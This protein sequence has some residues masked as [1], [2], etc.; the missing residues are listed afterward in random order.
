MAEPG[1][2]ALP[3]A[4]TGPVLESRD[5]ARVELEAAMARWL[6]LEERREALGAGS[7]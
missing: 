4:E 2:Y 6:E 5:E 3:F 1:F 7:S